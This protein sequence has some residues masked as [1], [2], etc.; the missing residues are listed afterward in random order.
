VLARAND[1]DEAADAVVPG[2]LIEDELD[3]K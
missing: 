2:D 1:E 3:P